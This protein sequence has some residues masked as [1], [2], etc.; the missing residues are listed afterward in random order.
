[1]STPPTQDPLG[2][3]LELE[4]RLD[5][6]PSRYGER[7]ALWLDEREVAHVESDGSVDLRVGRAVIRAHRADWRDRPGVILRPS[8]SAEWVHVLCTDG[9]MTTLAEVARTFLSA[10]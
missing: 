7:P 9:D 8:L 4:P 1:M 6:R 2:V 3:L 5:E 10:T